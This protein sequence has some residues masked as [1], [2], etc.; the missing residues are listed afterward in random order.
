MQPLSDVRVLDLSQFLSGPRCGQ[1]L[2]YLG[3]DVVKIEPPAGDTM[4]L[5]LAATGSERGM[6]TMHAGKRGLVLD[7]RAEKDRAL[8]LR[9]VDKADV[10]VENF[11]PG[12]MRKLGLDYDTLTVRRPMLIFAS[13]AGFGQDGPLAERTAFDIIA[14]ATGGAMHANH[15]PDRAP[16]MFIADLVSGAYAALGVLAALR[17]RERTGRGQR[18]DISMQDVVYFQNFWAMVDRAVE[19]DK[20]K[21]QSILG[22]PITDLLSNV[23]NPMCFWHSYAARDGHVVVVALTDRQWQ[24]LI[25]ATGLS[26]LAADEGLGDFVGRIRHTERGVAILT[27]WMRERT[28]A[29]IIDLLTDARVP[30][31]K[32]DDYADL[33]HDEQLTARG[34]LA[35][36]GGHDVPGN[37]IKMSAHAWTPTRPGPAMDEHRAEILRDWLGE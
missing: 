13:I 16:G 23:D 8:F 33:Q 24:A 22:A 35:H 5:Q 19:P 26:A 20:G 31:G 15:V 36:A 14:Q 2:A 1:L 29:E 10:L 21:M 34:M 4:R 12:I 3:A 17:T 28:C 18:I 27:G 7:L 6:H 32:V 9:L 25:E 30:C 11:A 37:P